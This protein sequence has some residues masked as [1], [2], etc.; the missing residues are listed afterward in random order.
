MAVS[1][2]AALHLG[3]YGPRRSRAAGYTLETRQGCS[4]F[5]EDLAV[6]RAARGGFGT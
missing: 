1:A 3:Q 6:R 4:G 5:D 2:V